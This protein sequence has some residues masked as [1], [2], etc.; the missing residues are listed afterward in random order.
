MVILFRVLATL[1][2]VLNP[3]YTGNS[4][5][6][7]YSLFLTVYFTVNLCRLDSTADTCFT[8]WLGR[9]YSVVDT[10]GGGGG[11]GLQLFENSAR[12]KFVYDSCG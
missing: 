9:T 11:G 7:G 4:Q 8:S 5:S 3:P 2:G 10:G 1:H 12:S 6:G